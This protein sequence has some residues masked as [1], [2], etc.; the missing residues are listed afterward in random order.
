MGFALVFC[1]AVFFSSVCL[2]QPEV[3][4]SGRTRD[5]SEGSDAAADLFDPLTLVDVDL[6]LSDATIDALN[7][8]PYSYQSATLT[9]TVDGVVKGP[10]AV[11]LKL[12]G[13]WGS[14]RSLDGKS[15]FKIKIPSGAR[16]SLFGLKKL[17]LNNM[18]QDPSKTHEAM[19]YR[20]FRAVGI[21]APRTGYAEVSVNG[22]SYGLYL[23]LETPDSVMLPRWF[24]STQHLLEGSYWTDVVPGNEGAFEVD[25]GSEVDFSDL[26][27]F[28]ENQNEALSDAEWWTGFKSLADEEQM[29]KMWAVEMFVGHWDGYAHTI[30]NNYYIHSDSSDQWSMLPWGTDQTWSDRLD[31]FATDGRAVLFRRCMAVVEC[32]AMYTRALQEVSDE[33]GTLNLSEMADDIA[34]VIDDSLIADP[35]KEHTYEYA[36]EVRGWDESF[37]NARPGDV[38]DAL[39]DFVPQRPAITLVQSGAQ[40]T[41]EITSGGS[42]AS[43]NVGFEVS[44]SVDGSGFGAPETTSGL[45]HRVTMEPGQTLRIRAR[46]VNAYGY[47][48]WSTVGT[49][50]Y[51][52]LPTVPRLSFERSS[53]TRI[54]VTWPGASASGSRIVRYEIAQSTNGN[55]WASPVRTTRLVS[56]FIHPRG[57]SRYYK[58]RVVTNSGTTAWVVTGPVS[59]R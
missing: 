29:T 17:T 19:T 22:Q 8:D 45:V 21:A 51:R 27:P 11:Q 52:V 48:P 12:K 57:A 20:L 7:S 56:T 16:A 2:P 23:N 58:L 5:Y 3:A 37:M 28:L 53:G 42:G 46:E 14:F 40:L 49:A 18:V 41:T 6:S 39:D 33:F 59:P 30:W 1:S 54:R 25:E 34:D 38:V 15:A 24:D 31:F 10:F 36:E 32:T 35:R 50:R 4:A 43:P 9:M 47:G 55:T 13:R 26:T 44:T